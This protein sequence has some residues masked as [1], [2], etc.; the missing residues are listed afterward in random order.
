M[1]IDG[2]E[3]KLS[4][5]SM[6]MCTATNSCYPAKR[7]RAEEGRTN[8]KDNPMKSEAQRPSLSV[9]VASLPRRLIGVPSFFQANSPPLR[10]AL[11]WAHLAEEVLTRRSS[12]R[13]K[14]RH[15]D[16]LSGHCAAERQ[17][18]AP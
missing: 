9:T 4:T 1:H 12:G 8:K 13:W 14:R 6:K 17:R 2:S 16:S 5:A 11:G 3:R 7:H 10:F 18:W 15:P